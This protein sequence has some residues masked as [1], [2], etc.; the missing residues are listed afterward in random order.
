MN[1]KELKRLVLEEIDKNKDKIIEAGRSIYKTPELGYKEVKSTKIASEFLKSLGVE[2]VDN[3]AVTGCMTSLNK[4][5]NGPKIAVMGELDSVVCPDHKDA[6]E[7]GNIHCC[8][9]NIQ[10]AGMLGCAVGIIKSGVLKYLDGKIDFMAVPSEEC[11]DLEFRKSLQEKNEIKYVGGKQELLYRGILDDVDMAMMFHALNFEENKNCVIKSYTN[12][13]VS[14]HA[15]FIGRASHAGIAPHEGIN[16]LN[17]A[18]L[19]TNNINAQ[20]ETFKDEDRV[21]ISTV[22]NHGGDIVNV[23]PSK[24]TI[25]AMVRAATVDA[26]ID[27]NEK[28]N[29]S[30]NAAAMAL[31]GEVIIEDTIGYLPLDSDDSMDFIFKKNYVELVGGSEESIVDVIKTA[32]S[33][34]FG[35]ISQIIPCIHPWIGG[36]SGSLHTKDYYIS[37]EE[38]AYIIPA[39]AM[40]MTI[41]DLLGDDA[42]VAKDIV[43]K[44]KPTFTKESYLDFMDKNT[45]TYKYDYSK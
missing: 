6:N 9:H 41:I 11:I 38:L 35:D 36:V 24:V 43:E 2:V 16:A 15:T 22:I 4:D 21:R 37:D 1:K 29:R 39:K 17:M 13:F 18:S 20:R 34:D 19:A 7:I 10:V 28:V 12:G 42:K 26:M 45:N 14:K 25:E 31:G 27:A 5:K 44:F 3:I 8:G 32:G 23:V 30:L 40:A 33:T